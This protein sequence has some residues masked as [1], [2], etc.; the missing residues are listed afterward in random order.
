MCVAAKVPK[1]LTVRFDALAAQRGATRSALI[2]ELI[3]AA[4]DDRVVYLPKAE[5]EAAMLRAHFAEERATL[6]LLALS[7][8]LQ[9]RL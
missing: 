4:V 5:T 3:E 9:K 2:R 6:R 7:G 8:G 1:S